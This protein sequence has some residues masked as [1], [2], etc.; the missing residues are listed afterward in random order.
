MRFYQSADGT[1]TCDVFDDEIE[2]SLQLFYEADPRWLCVTRV[3]HPY[4]VEIL[5]EPY[6]V[7]SVNYPKGTLTLWRVNA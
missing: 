7:V 4:V 3:T 6:E 2:M 5:G 1:V